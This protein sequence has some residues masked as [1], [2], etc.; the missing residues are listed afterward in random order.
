MKAAYVDPWAAIDMLNDRSLMKKVE[1]SSNTQ[2]QTAGAEIKTASCQGESA[3]RLT[4][5]DGMVHLERVLI[6]PEIAR[7]SL[8]VSNL[9]HADHS[10][11]LTKDNCV[12]RKVS[13]VAG[14]V[15]RVEET[16]SIG[17]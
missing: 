10:V 17:F 15:K 12:V 7:Y 1:P 16:Y 4:K 14:H 3:A 6:I 8:S 13:R 2:I 5:K 11:S 9:S